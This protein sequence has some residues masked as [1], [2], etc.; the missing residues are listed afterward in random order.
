MS[1]H[2]LTCPNVGAV[3]G[4]VEKSE[5][6]DFA[7]EIVLHLHKEVPQDHTDTHQE[8]KSNMKHKCS[9]SVKTLDSGI[10]LKE[11]NGVDCDYHLNRDF[12]LT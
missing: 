7:Q 3:Q 4:A 9:N 12:A 8:L 2:R 11:T 6:E 5:G 1:P 10:S